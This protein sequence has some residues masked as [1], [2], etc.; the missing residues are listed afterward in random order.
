MSFIITRSDLLA[1]KKEMVDKMM[2]YMMEVLRDA[3]G[4]SGERL[5]LGNLRMVSS[6]RGWW[7]KGIKEAIWKRGGG[8]WLVGKVNV[9]KSQLFENIFPKG[10]GGQDVNVE[11]LRKEAA[12]NAY[13][14][15]DL[16]EYQSKLVAAAEAGIEEE[17]S[18]TID[19][20]SLLSPAPKEVPFPAMPV[21]SP[22]PGTTASP[23]RL[24]FGDGRGELIDLPGL[25][26]QTLEEYVKP[27]NRLDLIMKHRVVPKR[28]T[29]KPGKSLL[30]D[31]LVR[32]KPVTPD[33]MFLAHSFLTLQPHITADGKTVEYEAGER[34]HPLQS[35]MIADE[36]K[37]AD[38]GGLKSAGKI[39]LKWDV[40]KANAGPLT[41]K[42][43]VG[44]KP[45]ILPFIIYAADVLIEGCG[46]VEI[47]AQI[48]KRSWFQPENTEAKHEQESREAEPELS[49]DEFSEIPNS[50]DEGVEWKPASSPSPSSSTNTP[51]YPEVEVFTPGGKSIGVRKPLNAW[52]TGGPKKRKLRTIRPRRRIL[53]RIER[54]RKMRN[55]K[56]RLLPKE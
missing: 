48:R 28:V 35:T 42:N 22:L 10:R 53:N 9:G 16:D 45:E 47:T 4:R 55:Q 29:L 38:A 39:Q 36:Q 1:P 44:L 25:R 37:I 52:L 51:R 6:H 19:G 23:I 33:L 20:T 15:I 32:I 56:D 7:T 11:K 40:T 46:W 30:L 8:G 24:P 34:A 41:R 26:R 43:A 54:S 27:E 31:G 12:E 50:H 49:F 14:A 21:I 3:L 13:Q 18:A 2:P 5:R 17:N